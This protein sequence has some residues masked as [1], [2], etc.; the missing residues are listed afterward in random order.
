MKIHD[1]LRNEEA[2]HAAWEAGKGAL[3]GA[4][5][6]GAGTAV[7][8]AIGY[9]CSP[10]YRGTTV[11]F[12]VYLQMSGMVLGGMIEADW[13]LRQYECQMRMQRRWM[14]ERAK[15]ERFEEEFG[16]NEGGK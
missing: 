7:L 3:V 4:A 1:Q 9:A 6:W 10:I 15:W 5:K 14:R 16:K 8:G 13:R 12:K 2:R 11:Q